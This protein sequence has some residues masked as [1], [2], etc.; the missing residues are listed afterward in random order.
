MS[1]ERKVSEENSSILTGKK[2]IFANYNGQP[3]CQMCL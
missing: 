3:Q 1:F 2:S